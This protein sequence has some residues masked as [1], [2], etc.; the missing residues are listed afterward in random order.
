MPVATALFAILFLGETLRWYDTLGMLLVLSSII[1]G[2]EIRTT[3]RKAKL[4]E[5]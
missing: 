5:A 1:V 2:A 3:M 4:T